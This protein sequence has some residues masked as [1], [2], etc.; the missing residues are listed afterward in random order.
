MEISL[1]LSNC[2]SF[3]NASSSIP[4]RKIPYQEFRLYENK[5]VVKD[6]KGLDKN[7]SLL[8]FKVMLDSSLNIQSNQLVSFDLPVNCYHFGCS[9]TEL[10]VLCYYPERVTEILYY[11]KRIKI[12]FPNLII[13]HKLRIKSPSWNVYD[14]NYFITNKTVPEI[15]SEFI[16][17][18][19][20]KKG[21]FSVPFSNFYG[22][23]GKMCYGRNSMPFSF[24]QNL[25]ALDWYYQV[26]F[27]SPFNDDL[28]IHGTRT[29]VSVSSWYN[30][31]EGLNKF[32]YDEMVS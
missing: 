4:E 29:R 15:P 5:V 21:I 12:P 3:L 18:A 32:P 30:K 9:S 16:S 31:L 27:N 11:D 14:T 10:I 19:D 22:G 2:T 26:I 13:H 6:L 7:I 8:D 1:D 28:G 20:P 23:D 17:F 24:N 25:R